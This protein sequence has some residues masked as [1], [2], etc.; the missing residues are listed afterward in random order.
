MLLPP[1]ST[2]SPFS[3]A[4]AGR[5]HRAVAP[6]GTQALAVVLSPACVGGGMAAEVQPLLGRDRGGGQARSGE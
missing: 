2:I 1:P 3:L 5:H 6:P 4:V